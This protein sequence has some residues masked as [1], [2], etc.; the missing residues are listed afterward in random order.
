MMAG[1]PPGLHDLKL[2]N[3]PLNDYYSRW[4]LDLG[5]TGGITLEDNEAVHKI[6]F[7]DGSV[8]VFRNVTFESDSIVAD[9]RIIPYSVVDEVHILD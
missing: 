2:N 8:M 5:H 3:Q 9:G 1:N 7:E 6:F 4:L